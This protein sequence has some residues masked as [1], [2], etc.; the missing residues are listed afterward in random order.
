MIPD[1]V[2]NW[3]KW[4]ALIALDAVGVFYST[5]AEKNILLK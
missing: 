2:Y 5:M 1:K 3:L 4:V